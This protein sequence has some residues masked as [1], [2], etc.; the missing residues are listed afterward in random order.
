MK[1]IVLAD[2][3]GSCLYPI[4]RG[5]PKQLLPINDEPM[6]YY[7]ISALKLAGLGRFL[8]QRHMTFQGSIVYL[9]MVL[10]MVCI[11]YGQYMQKV[12]DELKEDINSNTLQHV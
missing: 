4:T 3:S 6:A 5:C 9:E 1:G 7:P 2:G 10:T 11:L 8:S 12:I